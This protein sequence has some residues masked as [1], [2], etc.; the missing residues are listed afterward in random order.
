MSQKRN[1]K[2]VLLCVHE[3]IQMIRLQICHYPV[4]C[5]IMML[6]EITYYQSLNFKLSILDSIGFFNIIII[7]VDVLLYDS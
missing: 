6:T 2:P 3:V 7:I 1:V 4:N 5:L